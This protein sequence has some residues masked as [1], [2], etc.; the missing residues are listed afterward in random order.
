VYLLHPL[1]VSPTLSL[2]TALLG[3]ALCLLAMG[4]NAQHAADNAVTAADDAF[5]LTLGLESIGMYSPGQIRG[6]SPKSAG[7]LRI[8]GLYFDQQG[9]LSNRVVEGSAIRVGITEIGYAFPAPT[10][11]VDYALRRPGDGTASASIIAT[12]GPY[13][14]RGISID[15]S[16]PLNGK[17]FLLPIGL[18]YQFGTD[19]PYGTF[20]GYTS[21][22]TSAGF[23][24]QW[25]P[26]DNLKIR[27]LVD[28]QETRGAT[29]FPL[30][31]TA[32]PFL[33]PDI[34]RT[35]LGQD[36]AR[37]RNVVQNEGVLATWKLSR[38][39]T[40]SAGLFHSSA[41]NPLSFAD[42][43]TLIQPNGQAEHLVIG[44]PNQTVS[45]MSGE[46]RLTGR[47]AV[48]DWR[49]EFTVLSRGR[50][51]LA[52]H[53]GADVVDAGVATVG[54]NQQTPE[55]DFAYS[56]RS[57]DMTEEWRVGAAYRGDWRGLFEL[58][59]G[60][61]EDN[62]RKVVEVAG[63]PR[64]EVA[65]DPIRIYGNSALVLNRDLSLYAGYTQGLEDSGIAPSV[66]SNGGAVLPAS[67][68]WQ[69]D[70]GVRYTVTPRLKIIAGVFELEKPYFNLDTGGLDRALGLQQAKGTEFSI[71]GQPVNN[72]DINA[73]ILVGKVRILG[74]SLATEG[75]GSV[76]V[77][78]PRLQYSANVNYRILGWPFLSL[79]LS[80]IHFGCAPATVDNSLYSPAVTELNLGGRLKFTILGKNS[81]LRLQIQN[82]PNT[83]RWTNVFTPGL[84]EWA[85]PRTLF[86]YITTDM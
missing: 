85:G 27:A 62:Y 16:L 52:R 29:T 74:P 79:D 40:L 63:Q 48:G 2:P 50:D 19:T 7:N 1:V 69:A 75:V 22:V 28:W 8:D 78:Q 70:L 44:Y 81:S 57:D 13:Q 39:W 72:L 68:T 67:R 12:A 25:S 5:G 51:S 53:G 38:Q 43:Y 49:H 71:A 84:F 86:A 20:P 26:D 41:Q 36:W 76:A 80:A 32:G 33:P 61:Q 54:I 65:D 66:A 59:L 10:G 56:A 3:S 11:I 64:T 60:A 15:A 23:S 35:Y 17:E 42:L 18:G 6:F 55:P 4:A 82:L 45:S 37:G 21:R 58:Q 30:Y 47:F 24:P 14:A 34:P 9:L 73:G 77:G 83:Y 31:F 46:M